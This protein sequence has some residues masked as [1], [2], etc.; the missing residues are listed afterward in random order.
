MEELKAKLGETT[1]E[2]IEVAIAAVK[3]YRLNKSLK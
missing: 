1:P 3:L 2:E